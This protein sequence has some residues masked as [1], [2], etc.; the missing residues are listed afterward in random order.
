MQAQ[1]AGGRVLVQYGALGE[2]LRWATDRPVLGGFHDR[3]M[4]FQDADLFHFPPEDPRYEAGF[5]AYLE[6]YNVTRTTYAVRNG[7]DRPVRVMVRHALDG[8]QGVDQLQH[9]M[10]AGGLLLQGQQ[11]NLDAQQ[12][13]D[14]FIMELEAQLLLLQFGRGQNFTGDV[15]QSLFEVQVGKQA[16]PVPPLSAAQAMSCRPRHFCAA[17]S[18][19]V[20]LWMQ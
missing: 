12:C 18:P 5:A 14:N 16:A 9:R 1:P 17:G 2:Y 19:A 15:T 13:L 10:A 8:A 7:M 4:I 3:R 11:S 6:R 20:Q